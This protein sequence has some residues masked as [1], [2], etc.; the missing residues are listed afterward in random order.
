MY[1]HPSILPP[2][3]QE[4]KKAVEIH[5]RRLAC[6]NTKFNVFF[7]HVVDARGHQVSDY[8]VVSPKQQSENLLTGV[9]IL[10]VAD[11]Q[12][13][14]IRIYRPAIRSWSWEIPHGFIEAGEDGHR[15]AAREL[16]EETGIV[17]DSVESLGFI[18]PDAGV[19]AARV[20]LFLARGGRAHIGKSLELGL[21]EFG[22]FTVNAFKDMVTRSEI[23][24]TF[25]LSA[26]CRYGLLFSESAGNEGDAV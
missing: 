18:T 22:F 23:Q 26:W 21:R 11:G 10:P 9:A 25:T 20:H 19:L 4:N 24:D 8:L 12:I 7:D 14:L 16:A 15:A 6:E 5:S 1:Y 2:L 17:P 3:Y 13:G